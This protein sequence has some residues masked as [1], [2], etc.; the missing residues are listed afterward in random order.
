MPF[1]KEPIVPTWN[2]STFEDPDVLH[3]ADVAIV[4]IWDLSTFED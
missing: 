4:P 2:L 3:V 1:C